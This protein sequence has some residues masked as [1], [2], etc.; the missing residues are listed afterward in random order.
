MP[1]KCVAFS[2]DTVINKKSNQ[3][4]RAIF[5]D[6][7]IVKRDTGKFTD[8]RLKWIE[9]YEYSMKRRFV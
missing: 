1:I 5:L 9:A 3:R 2:Y 8:E 6:E 4:I 7:N